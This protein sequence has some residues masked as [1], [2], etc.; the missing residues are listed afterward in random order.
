MPHGHLAHS[1]RCHRHDYDHYVY[2]SAWSCLTFLRL[3][4]AREQ[5]SAVPQSMQ[6]A[7]TI[8]CF[9]FCLLFVCIRTS[10]KCAQTNHNRRSGAQTRV[11]R[12]K[13]ICNWIGSKKNE[14]R[15]TS[16][17]E[18]RVRFVRITLLLSKKDHCVKWITMMQIKSS[19]TCLAKLCFMVVQHKS[20]SWRKF[21][22]KQTLFL[23]SFQPRRAGIFRRCRMY[24]TKTQFA[25]AIQK[26]NHIYIWGMVETRARARRIIEFALAF[27][28]IATESTEANVTIVYWR[29]RRSF[30]PINDV[31]LCA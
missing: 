3:A 26:L 30:G 2:Q 11:R 1:G 23:K 7:E 16:A 25:K 13:Y 12:T 15:E 22:S 29:L 31:M 8:Y 17:F 28:P 4:A 9:N 20:I 14:I 27:D 18:R 24:A 21:E 6:K 5:C 10:P 19:A